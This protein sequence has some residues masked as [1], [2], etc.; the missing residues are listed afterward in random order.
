MR[1]DWQLEANRIQLW[2]GEK[3]PFSLEFNKLALLRQLV[4]NN[5]ALIVK[6]RVKF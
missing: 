4:C 3:Q 1:A 2:Q 5:D 6:Q